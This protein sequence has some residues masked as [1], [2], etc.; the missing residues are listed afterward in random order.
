MQRGFS[1]PSSI[2]FSTMH[3]LTSAKCFLSPSLWV[4]LFDWW[5]VTQQNRSGLHNVPES[6]PQCENAQLPPRTGLCA[7]G[8]RW[9]VEIHLGAQAG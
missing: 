5:F 9:G 8:R 1:F 6:P 4:A 7:Q 2:F 3:L